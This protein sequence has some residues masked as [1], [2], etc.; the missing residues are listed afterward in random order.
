[1]NMNSSMDNHSSPTSFSALLLLSASDLSIPLPLHVL[2]LLHPYS[3][4]M[5]HSFAPS[6]SE[7]DLLAPFFTPLI[8]SP[9]STV[10]PFHVIHTKSPF[11]LSF[12]LHLPVFNQWQYGSTEGGYG[13]V[14]MSGH[15]G[16]HILP[17]VSDAVNIRHLKLKTCLINKS[18]IYKKSLLLF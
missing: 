2:R 15:V 5:F 17:H 16:R 9:L 7:T 6:L 14:L 12:V 11:C 3:F 18:C 10:S 4:P 8:A 1:M 13:F